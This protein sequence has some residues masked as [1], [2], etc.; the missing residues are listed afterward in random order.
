MADGLTFKLKGI[1][2]VKRKLQSLDNDAR[3]RGGRLAL[4]KAANLV[5][6]TVKSN[7]LRIDDP[8]TPK[9]IAK[10]AAV[11]WSGKT[12]RTTGN[13]HFRVGI[14]GGARQNAKRQ[15]INTDGSSA[16]PGGDTYYWRFLEF[17]TEKMRAQPFFSNALSDKAGEA[18]TV[19][20]KEFDKAVGR[21]LKRAGK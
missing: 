3:Y 14:L 20:V 18:T 2:A 19:F 1:D 13:L 11:R 15:T 7:A 9:S 21:A 17:G 6:D 12:F 5:R 8:S 10:N 16:N 4:R